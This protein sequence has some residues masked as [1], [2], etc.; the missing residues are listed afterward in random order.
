MGL[1]EWANEHPKAISAGVGACVLIC[2]GGIVVEVLGNRRSINTTVPDDYF[3]IDDGS[4]YFRASGTNIAPFDYEGHVAVKAYVFECAGHKFVGYLE[5]YKPDA[6]KI[7]LAGGRIPP[8]VEINGREIKRPGESTWTSS[9][10]FKAM[11]K[12]INVKC[13]DGSSDAPDPIEP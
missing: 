2:I 5:R 3:S 8:S 11:A 1:R 10:D 9:S 12:V 7:V 6:R 13:P 4:T